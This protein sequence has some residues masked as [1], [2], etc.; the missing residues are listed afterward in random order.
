M[1]QFTLDFK[2]RQLSLNK[3]VAV[4]GILNVTPDSFFDG[5]KYLRPEAALK[6]VEEMVQEGADIIDIGGESTRPGSQLV[7]LQQEL[8]RVIPVVRRIR[9]LLRFLF[10]WIPTKPK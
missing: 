6:R 7:S 8:R 10:V 1:N 3:R 2:N 5:G 4:M 9:R